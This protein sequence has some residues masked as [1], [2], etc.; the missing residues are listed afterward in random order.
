[1]R[2]S[3]IDHAHIVAEWSDAAWLDQKEALLIYYGKM[4]HYSRVVNFNL[5]GGV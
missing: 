3:I 4:G 5:R 2:I 1:M